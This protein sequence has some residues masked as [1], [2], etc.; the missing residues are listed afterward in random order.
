MAWRQDEI[1]VQGRMTR[2]GG[3]GEFNFQNDSLA[4]DRQD[5]AFCVRPGG[6]VPGLFILFPGSID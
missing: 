4:G 2:L 3:A 6:P 1:G 5:S